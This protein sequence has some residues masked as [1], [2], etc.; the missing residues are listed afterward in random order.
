M[1]QFSRCC[2]SKLLQL[3]N[4][5]HLELEGHKKPHSLQSLWTLSASKM[6]HPS[7]SH[8]FEIPPDAIDRYSSGESLR[9]LASEYG[10]SPQ[11][12][13]R[14]LVAS[15]IQLRGKTPTA[16]HRARLS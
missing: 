15:G 5:A 2:G 6:Y 1:P 4:Y 8:R 9:D 12:L 11:T 10:T 3:D 7:M 14:R 13:G 16:Q